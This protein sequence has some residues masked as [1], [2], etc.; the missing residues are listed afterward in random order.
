[1][2]EQGTLPV[3]F[4]MAI[5]EKIEATAVAA[6]QDILTGRRILEVEGPYGL[7]LTTVEVGNDDL[8]RQPGPAEASAVVG[9]SVSVPM[10]YRR[11]ALSKRQIAAFEEMSQPLT[12][13]V[14]ADAAQAV[15]MREEEFVY[16]GQLD[17][18]LPGLLTAEGRNIL[19]G[20]EWSNVDQA[21]EDVIAAVNIL[22]GKG[23]RGP[24]SLALSP[25]LYNGLFRRY[26]GTDLLQIEHLKRLCTRGIVKAAIEGGVLIVPDVGPL[27]LGQDLQVS[28]LGPDAAHYNFTLSESL[29]L[30]IEAPDAICT[31]TPKGPAS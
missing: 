23:Y 2:T 20:G 22:D 21:L 14:V 13:K 31:I 1:M 8:C 25:T 10:I 24:Y 4:G 15:A 29:V 6:A 11:F 26:A 5:V 18:H 7:G 12:L 9:R 3:P 17:F 19:Q 27:V 16:R 30:K 28:Y